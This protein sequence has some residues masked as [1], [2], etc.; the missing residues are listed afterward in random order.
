MLFAPWISPQS[1]TLP[2]AEPTNFYCILTF[3]FVDSQLCGHGGSSTTYILYSLIWLRS[4]LSGMKSF[5]PPF[6][7]QFN[8][9]QTCYPVLFMKFIEFL[10]LQANFHLW[11]FSLVNTCWPRKFFHRKVWNE[12]NI[13]HT[14]NVC[15]SALD[16]HIFN[17]FC[18][19]VHCYSP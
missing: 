2:S 4:F 9:L 12:E 11:I 18:K 14:H 15:I 17:T 6:C 8:D 1:I 5:L 7:R 10:I 19:K 16:Q 13:L 3:K